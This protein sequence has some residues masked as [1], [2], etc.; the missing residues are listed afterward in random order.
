VNHNIPSI[1]AYPPFVI[2]ILEGISHEHM[3]KYGCVWKWDIPDIPSKYLQKTV[4]IETSN[5]FSWVPY[6][7]TNHIWIVDVWSPLSGPG[8]SGFLWVQWCLSFPTQHWLS[9]IGSSWFFPLQMAII[10]HN[11]W[12]GVFRHPVVWRRVNLLSDWHGPLL[13]WSLRNVRPALRMESLATR[14]SFPCHPKLD[15]GSWILG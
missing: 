3:I 13:E 11:Y 12:S 2:H 1:I 5:G 8:R 4:L 7:Q 10:C 9:S 14:A 15:G 6:F